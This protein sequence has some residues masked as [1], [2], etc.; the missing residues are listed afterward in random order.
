MEKKIFHSIFIVA[1]GVLIIITSTFAHT[2]YTYYM[3]KEVLEV[4]G[5]TSFA[6]MLSILRPVLITL[7]GL[8]IVATIV[9][10]NVA[11]KIVEPIL[12]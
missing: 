10:S 1:F 7:A 9:A 4:L 6:L 12:R 11:K 3:D 2:L 5:V 8:L